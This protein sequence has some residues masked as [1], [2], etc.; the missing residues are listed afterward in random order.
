M[1]GTK[2]KLM[3][4][5]KKKQKNVTLRENKGGVRGKVRIK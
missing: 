3:G 2:S 5:K 1:N 4:R